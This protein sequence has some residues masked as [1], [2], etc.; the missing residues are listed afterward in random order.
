MA[1]LKSVLTL[2]LTCEFEMC[3]G[4]GMVYTTD[5]KSVGTERFLRVRLPFRAP[6]EK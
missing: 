6:L 2:R 1:T 5:L 4:G 3:A